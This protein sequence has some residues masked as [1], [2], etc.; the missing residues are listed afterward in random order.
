ML[1][2]P[3]MH[4]QANLLLT[5]FSL[6]VFGDQVRSGS[7]KQ[8]KQ[9]RMRAAHVDTAH[10]VYIV[11]TLFFSVILGV[12]GSIIGV[13]AAAGVFW[14]LEFGGE[15][16][17]AAVP[18][19]FAPAI[20]YLQLS[21]LRP[22]SLFGLF[23]FA[24]ALGATVLAAGT[25]FLRWELLDQRAYARST[26]IEATL[27]QTVAFI[28]ALS[29]SGMSIPK[30]LEILAEHRD[31]YGEAANELAIVVADM[32][33]F[34]TD[35]ITA[36]E[37][38]AQYTPSENMEEF[39]DNLAS[40]LA[41]GRNLS[42]FLYQQYETYRKEAASQQRQY[43]DLL[44]TFAEA[45]VTVL[46][47]GPLFLITILVVIGL[48]L[49]DTLSLVRAI[50]YIGIP[51]GTLAFAVYVDSV[52]QSMEVHST[53]K[54]EQNPADRRSQNTSSGTER[55]AD[56]RA[57]L[58]AYDSIIR[59]IQLARQPGE[60]IVRHPLTTTIFTVPIGILWVVLNID[61]LTWSSLE[62]ITAVDQPL[63]EASILVLAVYTITYEIKQRQRKRL[64]ADIP[65]FLDR[66]A[67]ANNAGMTILKS[68]RRVAHSDLGTLQ[69]ALQKTWNDIQWGLDIK[70]ALDRLDHRSN[71]PAVTRVVALVG[72]AMET[73]G[74]IGPVVSIAADQARAK[75]RLE[76]ERRQEMLTYL[77]VIY[78]S[79]LV[80]LGIIATLSLSFIPA[81][82][83]AS[84][85]L[86]G[87]SDLPTGVGITPSFGDVNTE[88]YLTIFYHVSSIQAI[89]SGL[90]A[91]QLGE[92]SIRS[93]TK[94]ATIMLV[95]TYVVFLII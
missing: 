48:V 6:A 53:R 3:A 26:E 37:N 57:Q 1:I 34:G 20:A 56:A 4:D 92:G 94:H 60:T 17:A 64:E 43:L 93:G 41:S 73:S 22:R 61:S 18:D 21:S 32:N 46:V 87:G 62:I 95:C 91:G 38:M 72:N 25:Y 77:L 90:I 66:L 45:Y 29:R 51:L 12:A 8:N 83:S 82:E 27:P 7:H 24:S 75:E 44:S 42:E 14:V 33:L 49:E 52:T 28:Y 55:W 9:L 89:C 85:S 15:P 84:S 13:Y 65:D 69:S 68:F 31:V 50:G 67:S 63:V 78:I 40:V 35:V 36:L 11:K 2:V 74:D 71:S 39:A 81:V 54:R 70:S 23:V 86:S 30:V 79:F 59:I 76:A 80:F 10:D 88:S 58:A 16:L 5:R 47:A 19:L